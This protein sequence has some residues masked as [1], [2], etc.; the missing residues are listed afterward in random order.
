MKLN[1]VLH[2]AI[3]KNKAAAATKD[4]KFVYFT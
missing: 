3:T 4:F 1:P 2:V